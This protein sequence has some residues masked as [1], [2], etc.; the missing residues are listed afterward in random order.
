MDQQKL[1]PRER[2]AVL[3]DL[4]QL[5]S[6]AWQTDEIRQHRPTPVDEAKW[7]FTTIEQTLWNA[8]PK[9]MRE[10]DGIVQEHCGQS[11]PL[12]VAPVRFGLLMAVDRDGNPNVTIKLPRSAVA[13]AVESSRT[14]FT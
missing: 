5:I 14:V 4:K 11:L 3:A 2:Q 6:A 1:T 10:L 8:V 7:G 13:I 9:F 12:S